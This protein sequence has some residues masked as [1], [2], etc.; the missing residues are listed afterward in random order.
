MGTGVGTTVRLEP[1]WQTLYCGPHLSRADMYPLKN[2]ED[3][4]LPL[5]RFSPQPSHETCHTLPPPSLSSASR[6]KIHVAPD[7][8]VAP[9]FDFDFESE[10]MCQEQ[11]RDMILQEVCI[12]HIYP[13]F[14]LLTL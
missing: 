11:L 13:R 5:Y 10:P 4:L 3:P 14:A 12:L 6:G 1:A 7:P 2:L 8:V 9:G